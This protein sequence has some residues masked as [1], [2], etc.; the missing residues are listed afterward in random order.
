MKYTEKIGDVEHV[1]EAETP[2]KVNNLYSKL[3]DDETKLK[4]ATLEELL[5]MVGRK[6][7]PFN[8]DSRKH[9]KNYLE[10]LIE[11]YERNFK[12]I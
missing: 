3:N 4:S 8:Y 6:T 10:K 1:Y 12:Y 7:I 11:C 5:E 9:I 2:E